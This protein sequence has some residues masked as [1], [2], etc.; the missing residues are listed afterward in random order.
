LEERLDVDVMTAAM[1][2][3]KQ[4]IVDYF[5]RTANG[6]VIGKMVVEGDPDRYFFGLQR[7]GGTEP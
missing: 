6:A 2:Y 1:V 7:V 5:R 3:D 4:P